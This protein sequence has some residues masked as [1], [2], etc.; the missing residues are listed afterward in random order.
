MTVGIIYRAFNRISGKSYIGKSTRTLEI[1]KDEHLTRTIKMDYKFGRALQKYKP[2]DWEWT[3]LAEIEVNKLDEYEAFFIKDL[4]TF[5]QGYNTLNGESWKKGGTPQ[6]CN[7]TI[8][9]LWHPE[10]GEVRGTQSELFKKFGINNVYLLLGKT[11]KVGRFVLLKNKERYD[12]IF[13]IYE[14]YHPDFGIVKGNFSEIGHRYRHVFGKDIRL[15]SLVSGKIKV[16]NGWVLAENKDEYENI[17]N[18][19]KKITLT[20]LEYGIKTLTI[21]DF[22]K[23]YN[24][25]KTNLYKVIKKE[26]VS[27]KG[28][29]LPENKEIYKPPINIVTITHPELGTLTLNRKEFKEK[30]N[31]RNSQVLSHLLKGRLKTYKGWRLV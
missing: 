6:K 29:Y 2:E 28:W 21:S 15:R 16:V 22:T 25:N 20:H 5:K 14:F 3:V 31:D 23:L 19:S 12:K 11:E 17:V 26:Q 10:Y 18:K 8:Y 7:P 9:E 30:F 1:R 24:L 27:T 13:N 4:N